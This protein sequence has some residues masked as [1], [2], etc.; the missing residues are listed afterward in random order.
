[1]FSVERRRVAAGRG[2]EAPDGELCRALS[3]ELARSCNRFGPVGGRWARQMCRRLLDM[4]DALPPDQRVGLIQEC[5]VVLTTV[6]DAAWGH[7][8]A[9]SRQDFAT[10]NDNDRPSRFASA[11]DEMLR[12]AMR[13]GPPVLDPTSA[14]AASAGRA[15][16]E[17][18]SVEPPRGDAREA[19]A[20][21]VAVRIAEDDVLNELGLPTASGPGLAWRSRKETVYGRLAPQAVAN[22]VTIDVPSPEASQALEDELLHAPLA[23]VL[24]ALASE[25]SFRSASASAVLRTR[26]MSDV[27]L[28][29]ARNL[30]DA[31]VE[32][33]LALLDEVSRRSGASTSAWLHHFAQDE[34]AE[35]RLRAL[36]LLGT[37]RD[38]SVLR[39]VHA[40]A[41][42]DEDP[43]IR[44][45]ARRLE[46][47]A[48]EA[49]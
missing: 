1:M 34:S 41:L 47:A 5:E 43:R 28:Q 14:M 30:A 8:S 46:P 32:A 18:P 40:R 42:G 22:G 24:D 13:S 11:A 7:A 23:A 39:Q 35:V 29:V 9:A 31:G 17:P 33:R 15:T 20:G 21:P 25:D 45:L 26:G 38:D 6:E 37:S 2:S 19:G 36:T 12:F 48:A 4:V 16:G 10:S 49:R 27:D 44:A 3:G